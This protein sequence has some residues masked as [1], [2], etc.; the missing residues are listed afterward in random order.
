MKTDKKAVS[1]SKQEQV[2]TDA[3]RK[4]ADHLDIKASE[5]SEVLGLSMASI[6]RLNSGNYTLRSNKKEFE[7]GLE[8]VR[9]FRGIDAISG[10]DNRSSRSWLRAPNKVLREA[11]INLIKSVKGLV[12]TVG[13][14]DTFRAKI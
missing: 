13:Y 1:A 8:F 2:L 7:L 14:V 6:S 12:D 9:L 4:A 3:V 11:P 10:G 5:L